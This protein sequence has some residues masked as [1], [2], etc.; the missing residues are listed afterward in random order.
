M[1]LVGCRQA[2][3]TGDDGR[4]GF[5]WNLYLLFTA[6][7]SS[8]KCVGQEVQRVFLTDARLKECNFVPADYVGSVVQIEYNRYGKVASISA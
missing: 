4:E 6:E 1:T 7:E 2:Q 5:G 3:F 8:S